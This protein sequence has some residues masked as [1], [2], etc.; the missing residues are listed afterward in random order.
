MSDSFGKDNINGPEDNY[1]KILTIMNDP[2]KR[3]EYKNQFKLL[4]EANI[5]F[6]IIEDLITERFLSALHNLVSDIV[7][8][9][10]SEA[11]FL[12][13]LDIDTVT[14]NILLCSISST[15]PKRIFG[16]IKGIK[17][18]RHKKIDKAMILLTLL[19]T[20]ELPSRHTE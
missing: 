2:E 15:R 12:D 16:T 14:K 9:F 17:D 7:D 19:S 6:N 3:L 4:E 8:G 13:I 18:P 1:S 5:H 10:K 11:N 20:I